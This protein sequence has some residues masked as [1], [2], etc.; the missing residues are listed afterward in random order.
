MSVVGLH[1]IF[2]GFSETLLADR[3]TAVAV[4]VSA[5]ACGQLVFMLCA[6]DR[7]FPRAARRLVVPAELVAAAV[8]LGGMAVACVQVLA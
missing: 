3:G 6:C 5:L 4:G 7:I 8:F 2:G 1:V